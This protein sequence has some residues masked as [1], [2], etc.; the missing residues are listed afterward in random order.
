MTFEQLIIKNCCILLLTSNYTNHKQ[1]AVVMKLVDNIIYKTTYSIN[2]YKNIL[3]IVY[4]LSPS[5]SDSKRK[6][7]IVQED[8]EVLKKYA[9]GIQK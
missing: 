2:D 9:S 4:W 7:C 8:I 5:D 6:I 1:N 3:H